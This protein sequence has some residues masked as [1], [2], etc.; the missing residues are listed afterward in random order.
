MAGVLPLLVS[1]ILSQ[2]FLQTPGESVKN[3]ERI[4]EIGEMASVKLLRTLKGELES[5]LSERG[6]L[7][8][9]EVCS[10]SAT[11]LTK[12]VSARM[13]PGISIKRTSFRYRN[14][15]NAPTEDEA[16]ALRYFEKE[17]REKNKLPPYYIQ[18]VIA[19]GKVEYN[20]Y[21]P[22]VTEPLCLTCHGDK[23]SMSLEL[24]KK[25]HEL[26]P[27]D[28]ATGYGIGDLRGAVRVAIPEALLH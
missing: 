2:F 6:P 20:Y 28:N 22:I 27:E 7:G 14:P 5:A 3:E 4:K 13:Y 18:R 23:R 19:R 21:K 10:V 25:I 24:L 17:L 8:A 11:R 26:Y 15:K 12:E 1:C 9:V 16:K